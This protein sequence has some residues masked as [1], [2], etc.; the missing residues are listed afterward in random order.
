MN[1]LEKRLL[2][3]NSGLLDKFNYAKNQVELL[4]TKYDSNFPTYTDHSIKHTL[5]VFDIAAQLFSKTELDN[6]NDDEIYIL[7]MA[8]ILHDIGMCIPKSKI[9]EISKTK[10]IDLLDSEKDL[11][12]KIREIHHELSYD[13]ILAE[14]ELLKIPNDNYTKAIALVAMGHRK[15][16]LDDNDT[17]QQRYFVKNGREFVC[18]PYLACIIRL[19]DELDITNIRTP[20]LLTKYYMPNNEQSVTEWKKHIST[21]QINYTEDEVIFQVKCSDQNNLAAL[22]EQF[23][24]I[25]DVSNYCQKIIRTIPTIDDRKFELRLY[26]IKPQYVFESFDPKGIKFSFNVQNVVN[27]FIGEDLYENDLTSIREALQNSIDSCRYRKGF[28]KDLYKPEITI[29]ITDTTIQ[30]RDNGI[31]MDEFIIENFFGKLGSSFYQQ[32]DVKKDF[33]A[34]GQFGVGVFSYFLLSEFI[35]IETKSEKSDPLKFRIDKDPKNYFHFFDKTERTQTGTTITFHLKKKIQEKYNSSDYSDYIKKVF[36][37]IE[38][39]IKINN[40]NHDFEIIKEPFAINFEEEIEKRITTLCKN[41]VKKI[42]PISCYINNDEFE[43]ECTLI[44]N[45]I[46]KKFSLLGM[47]KNFNYESFITSDRGHDNTEISISQKGIFVNT[48]SSNSITHVIGNINLK[49]STKININR[50]DFSNK[51]KLN[52]ITALFSAELIKKLFKSLKEQFPIAELSKFSNQFIADYLSVYYYSDICNENLLNSI[53]ENLYVKI[54]DN[55]K[56]IYTTIG[57]LKSN[58]NELII[59]SDLEDYKKMTLYLKT[60]VI[61]ATGFDY[62]GSYRGIQEIM[63]AYLKFT[64]SIIT[65]DNKSF[66]KLSK[67]N[68]DE[69]LKVNKICEKVMKY[70]FTINKFDNSK[71][72]TNIAKSRMIPEYSKNF[73][74]LNLNQDHPFTKFIIDN[75]DLITKDKELLK[76]AKT[77]FELLSKISNSKTIIKKDLIQLNQISKSLTT[78]GNI[79]IFSPV[80]FNVP[81]KKTTSNNQKRPLKQNSKV[82]IYQESV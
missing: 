58:Y 26:K 24:K 27:T 64:P 19:A 33:E 17:Y 80:D 4:L 9:K 74:E 77:C 42:Q 53:K 48:Y 14:K 44:I 47:G 7:S 51:D 31:G 49:K 68:H 37:Y 82:V 15:V 55:G 21:T 46:T 28:L 41:N 40:S 66:T 72:T 30:I 61:I 65:K 56:I 38:F 25:Q 67:E 54:Y 12:N 1:A 70:D 2:L 3:L 45:K 29:A 78:T 39:P 23:E 75:I 69:Y 32:G 36:K 43:G 22:E 20:K 11:Q 62:R 52:N 5:Q 73:D 50:K 18:L 10:K 79:H 63:T 60:P 57:E 71:L 76:I 13:F 81:E 6:L 59:I 16:A 34:I 35:D 8:C